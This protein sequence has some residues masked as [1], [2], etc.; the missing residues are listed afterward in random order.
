MNNEEALLKDLISTRN[1]GVEEQRFVKDLPVLPA[2]ELSPRSSLRSFFVD[3][4][5]VNSVLALQLL[6]SSMQKEK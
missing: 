2:V 4:G 5:D 1:K 3:T 6:R